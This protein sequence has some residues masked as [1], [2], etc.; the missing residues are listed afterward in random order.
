MRHLLIT[1]LSLA[2]TQFGFCGRPANAQTTLASAGATSASSGWAA[3]GQSVTLSTSVT[4]LLNIS[5]VNLGYALINAVTGARIAYQASNFNL[6]QGQPVTVSQT[7]AIPAGAAAGKYRAELSML[8]AAR[9][10]A[11]SPLMWSTPRAACFT[12]TAAPSATYGIPVRGCSELPP[13][14]LSSVGSQIVDASG[15]P[16][17]IASIGWTGTDESAGVASHGLWTVSYK[18]VLNAIRGAGFNAVRMPWT[19]ADLFTRANGYVASLGTIDNGGT[20]NNADL[21]DPAFPQP[22]AQGRYTYKR[23]IDIFQNYVDYAGSIG[24]KIIFDHHSNEGTAGQQ[25]NGLWF[26]LD[27]ANNFFTDGFVAG[28]GHTTYATFKNNWIALA[29]KFKS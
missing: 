5:N 26:D 22:N 1:I 13:G 14:Y 21:R 15:N 3:P 10:A 27:P 18:T 24:L 7:I 9:A 8:N 11:S 25:A 2:A 6:I 19:D 29:K 12:V 17:R 28:N 4:P 20:G 16:V 23:T